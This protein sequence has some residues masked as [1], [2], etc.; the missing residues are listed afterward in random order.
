MVLKYQDQIIS[1][2]NGHSTNIE[3]FGMGFLVILR[4]KNKLTNLNFNKILIE[5]GFFEK[6]I[7][8]N[9]LQF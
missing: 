1:P 6:G 2:K 3:R 9:I 8:I 7:H 5:L 4:D